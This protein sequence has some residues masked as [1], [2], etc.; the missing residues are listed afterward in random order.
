MGKA[1]A[2]KAN[3]RA[4]DQIEKYK[5]VLRKWYPGLSIQSNKEVLICSV[6][7]GKL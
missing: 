7:R 6:S 5:V 2:I 1:R 3:K 4:N